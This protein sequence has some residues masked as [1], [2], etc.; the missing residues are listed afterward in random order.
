MEPPGR[1]GMTV[2]ESEV[3]LVEE[4]RP[5]LLDEIERRTDKWRR[6]WGMDPNTSVWASYSAGDACPPCG[7]VE[8]ICFEAGIEMRAL[9]RIQSGESTYVDM[10]VADRVLNAVDRGLWEVTIYKKSE[11]LPAAKEQAKMLT[12]EMRRRGIPVNKSSVPV[13]RRKL[14]RGESL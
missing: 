11:V 3:V 8:K 6:E 4:I 13:A 10:D 1:E 9:Y 2:I 14:A 12:A 7:P 5:I